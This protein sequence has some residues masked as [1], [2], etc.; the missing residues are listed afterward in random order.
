MQ[1][2]RFYQTLL[3]FLMIPVLGWAHPITLSQFVVRPTHGQNGAAF[4][5]L[6]N[7]SAKHVKLMGATA[8]ICGHIELHTHLKDG[9]IYRMRSIPYIMINPGSTVSLEPGGLHIMLMKLKKPLIEGETVEMTLL[10]ED[11]EKQIVSVPV[12]KIKCCGCSKKK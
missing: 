5:S 8:D 2:V 7:N 3:L 4:L 11:E 9:N 10:F 6:T 1:T 12:K